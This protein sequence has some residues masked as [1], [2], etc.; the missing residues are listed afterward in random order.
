MNAPLRYDPFIRE[1]GFFDGMEES[2][3]GEWVRWTDY[4]S[5]RKHAFSESLSWIGEVGE[6]S[7]QVAKLKEDRQFLAKTVEALLSKPLDNKPS[8][9]FKKKHKKKHA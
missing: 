1:K 7:A 9:A 4:D 3:S 6:L 8:R 5:M 2:D